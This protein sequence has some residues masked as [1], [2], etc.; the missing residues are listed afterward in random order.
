MDAIGDIDLTE[1]PVIGVVDLKL[2]HMPENSAHQIIT[3]IIDRF[4]SNGGSVLQI[5]CIDP[6]ELRA[7]QRTPDQYPNLVVRVSGFSATFV[8]LPTDLQD[9]IIARSSCV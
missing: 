4:I 6:A 1:F 9:E 5:N 3:P 8:S 2:P 7:A